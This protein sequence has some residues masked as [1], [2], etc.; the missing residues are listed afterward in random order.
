V[1]DLKDKYYVFPVSGITNV[2]KNKVTV[3]EG[4]FG[5]VSAKGDYP[6]AKTAR[7]LL[8]IWKQPLPGG[9]NVFA[10]A[11]SDGRGVSEEIG[12]LKRALTIEVKKILLTSVQ[13]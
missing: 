7:E 13:K 12:K 2:A 1:I 10:M 4:S 8:E 6:A 5:I 3:K 11:D 9:G